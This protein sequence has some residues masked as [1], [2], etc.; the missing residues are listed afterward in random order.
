MPEAAKRRTYP[1]YRSLFA[2]RQWWKVVQEKAPE[3]ILT[4]VVAAILGGISGHA[5]GGALGGII[6]GLIGVITAPLLAAL[7]LL[8]WKWLTAPAAIW[9][10][11]IEEIH[12]QKEKIQQL[13]ESLSRLS[14]DYWTAFTEN[15]IALFYGEN[16]RKTRQQRADELRVLYEQH[17]DAI[18]RG[19][20]SRAAG[21]IPIVRVYLPLLHQIIPHGS[22]AYENAEREMRLICSQVER[23]MAEQH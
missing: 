13:E 4:A 8:I 20:F 19:D 14:S 11:Q 12:S 21:I 5:A 7:L 3:A 18:Q 23:Y 22:V 6:G 10:G 15:N 1:A 9:Q 17:R 16:S 2:W